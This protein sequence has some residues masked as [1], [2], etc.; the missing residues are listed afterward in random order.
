MKKIHF[1]ISLF[2]LAITIGCSDDNT[3]VDLESITAPTNISALATVTQDNTGKVTFL[4]KGEG[5]TQYEIYFGDG[6][7]SPAIVSP[8]AT[9]THVYKEGVYQ[10]K[11]VGVTLDGKRT[12]AIQEVTVSFLQPTDLE[13]TI[14]PDLS[15]N[16]AISVQAKAKLE[17]SFNVYFGD[18]ANEVPTAFMEGET[19][20]H[21]YTNLGDYTVK[22]VALSGGTA[23]TTE[24]TQVTISQPILLPVTF[25][26][27]TPAFGNF[28]GAVSSVIANP[29]V[30]SGNPSAKVAQLNKSQGAEVWA[31]SIVTL[32]KPIDFTSNKIMKIKVWS[33]KAGIV[34][35]MKLENLTDGTISKEVDVT[36]TV[37]NGWEELSFDF[38]TISV[39]EKYQKIVVFF[40]FGNPGTGAN[41]YY[42]DIKLVAGAE[43]LALPLTFQSSTL[44]YTFDNFGGA[45]TT[46]IDN[47]QSS[48]NT[49]SK[50]AALV[51]SNGSEVWG[52]SSILLDDPIDFSSQKKIKIKV[53]SPKA[54]IVVKM[55]LERKGATNPDATNIEVDVTTTVTNGWE[56]LTFDFAAI[57]NANKYQRVVVFF[58]FGKAGT[59]AT[60]YFDDIK[61]SN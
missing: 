34:V 37:A 7:K 4:P 57:N 15:N 9:V 61:Q 21:V 47:P 51:K 48:G 1:I 35:K 32:D 23:T 58:D 33:P 19:I 30:N 39:S 42:D 8:G 24:S 59:G 27:A 13:V 53:W 54:D 26:T 2:L 11:I 17:T 6:T 38:S 43:A 28:G 18:V 10:S 49:S 56:E 22:V 60:Y 16:Y 31:G 12:E 46:V 29:D 36:N 14:T 45:N 20:K 55:K 52:G 44:T 50:V 3:A 25:E 5:V 40:D 41:Y